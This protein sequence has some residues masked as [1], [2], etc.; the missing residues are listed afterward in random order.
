MTKWTIEINLDNNIN[1]KLLYDKMNYQFEQYSNNTDLW[2]RIKSDPI[3]IS[4]DQF[5][6]QK[7]E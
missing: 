2:M 5:G 3:V 6:N 7:F 4:Y 1:H